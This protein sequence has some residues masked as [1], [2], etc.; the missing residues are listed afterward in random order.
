LSGDSQAFERCIGVGGLVLFPS[1]TVYGLACDPEDRFAVE[2]LCLL[3]RRALDK[4]SAVMFFDV[5]DAV[6]ARVRW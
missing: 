3:K 1:D 2:R 5:A 4:P 6:P